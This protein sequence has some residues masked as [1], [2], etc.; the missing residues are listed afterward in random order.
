MPV[1]KLYLELTDSCNLNC[2]ICY[3][4]SWEEKPVHMD[5]ALYEKIRT[6]IYATPSI[7]NIVFGGI[8]E[9]SCAPD[10][11]ERLQDFKDHH[12][13]ITSN[14]VALT[15][16]MI[17]GM[18]VNANLVMI[19]IDGLEGRFLKIRGTN[20]QRIVE[21]IKRI[22]AEKDRTGIRTLQV[23]IQFVLSKDNADDLLGVLKLACDLKVATF[24][25]SNLLPQ[26]AENKDKILYSR[27]E[28][29]ETR[30]LFDELRRAA[31][32]KGMSTT[33]PSYELKTDRRCS[34]IEDDALFINAK[35][36]A[37]PCYRFSHSSKEYVFGREK[38]VTKHVFGSV[39]KDSISDIYE[40]RAYSRF[41][42]SVYN[43]RYPSCTDC[44][45]VDNCDA[46]KGTM[47]DCWT[48]APS[49]ADCLWARRIVICP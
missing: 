30:K 39:M 49:C 13:T 32:L 7:R 8:G 38:Q 48:N 45:L 16:E 17:H 19:S 3:R 43:G 15:D 2:S 42:K 35:G 31:F 28:N 44:E 33:I 10:F 6:E 41:R 1:K 46:V 18:V 27:F 40:D 26:V 4:R 37:V 36:E 34:F 11:T 22:N 20:L 9:P 14:G 47:T 25:V 21:N 24:V 23:G 29:P 12:L 5:R